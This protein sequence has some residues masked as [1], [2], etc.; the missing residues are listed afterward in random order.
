ML[1]WVS[2]SKVWL[3]LSR[4]KVSDPRSIPRLSRANERLYQGNKDVHVILR[5]ANKGPNYHEEDVRAAA[6]SIEK[7]RPGHLPGI[8]VDCSRKPIPS[9]SCGGVLRTMRQPRELCI[10]GPTR[11][12][13]FDAL[14]PRRRKER[15]ADL[16][17]MCPQTATRRK[18]TSISHVYLIQ[19][20]HS[21]SRERLTPEISLVS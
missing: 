13:G 17:V 9:S 20:V 19:Y 18:I 16:Y 1:S 12:L 10:H 2:P 4:R 14:I 8:M 21:C 15:V 7:A 6:A 11:G 5:G 3:P